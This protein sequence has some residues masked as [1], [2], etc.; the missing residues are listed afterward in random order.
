MNLHSHPP[1][2]HS[3]ELWSSLFR[4]CVDQSLLYPGSVCL[5]VCNSTHTTIESLHN[6]QRQE[7]KPH[8]HNPMCCRCCF[9]YSNNTLLRRACY[10]LLLSLLSLI[11][12]DLYHIRQNLQGAAHCLD[13]AQP[14]PDVTNFRDLADSNFR[15][16]SRKHL[17][18]GTFFRSS[19]LHAATALTLHSMFAAQHRGINFVADFRSDDEAWMHPDPVAAIQKISHTTQHVVYNISD[20][21]TWALKWN[22]INGRINETA[23]VGIMENLNVGFALQ[24]REYFARFLKDVAAVSRG[25]SSS[26]PDSNDAKTA[27]TPAPNVPFLIHCTAGTCYFFKHSESTLRN[28]FFFVRLLLL[29]LQGKIERDGPRL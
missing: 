17:K 26:T 28:S 3:F 29:L 22:M 1:A 12:Y 15:T 20:S 10:G 27:P 5:A 23:M 25:S 18:K 13:T 21:S 19:R 11:V 6:E 14:Y 9:C 24:H 16:P 4:V 7:L 2:V 8:H